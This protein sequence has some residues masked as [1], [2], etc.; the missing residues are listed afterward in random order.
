MRRI[1][2]LSVFLFVNYFKT[3]SSDNEAI[4]EENIEKVTGEFY[5]FNLLISQTMF[6]VLL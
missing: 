4:T 1:A 6:I 2:F 5:L 3:C